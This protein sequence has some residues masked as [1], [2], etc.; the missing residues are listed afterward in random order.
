MYDSGR[1]TYYDLCK[2]IPF[3]VMLQSGKVEQQFTK[4]NVPVLSVT[5][6]VATQY[7]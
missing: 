6:E 7:K 1:Y 3:H 5:K 4:K 2:Y